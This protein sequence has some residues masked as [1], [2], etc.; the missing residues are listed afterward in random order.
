MQ[1]SRCGAGSL[2]SV[3]RLRAAEI[4]FKRRA[5][6]QADQ[7]LCI[8]TQLPVTGEP[9]VLCHCLLQAWRVLLLV[10]YITLLLPTCIGCSDFVLPSVHFCVHDQRYVRLAHILTHNLYLLTC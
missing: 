1:A 6:P 8:L 2:A 4:A 3:F 5:W 9:S 7:E 10:A